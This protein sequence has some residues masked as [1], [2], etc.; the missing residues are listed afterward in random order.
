MAPP[1]LFLLLKWRL[2][3]PVDQRGGLWGGKV[4]VGEV[5]AFLDERGGRGGGQGGEDVSLLPCLSV[6]KQLVFTADFSS[7]SSEEGQV[8][9][10]G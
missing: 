5:K 10:C 2:K 8:S 6:G 3:R 9:G 1:P 4:G 7:V